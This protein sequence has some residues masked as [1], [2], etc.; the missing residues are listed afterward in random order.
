V[1]RRH[2]FPKRV[3]LAAFERAGG[4]CERCTA[5]L[6]PGKY[7]YDHR[8][9]LALGGESTLANCV[10]QCLACDGPKTYRQDIPAIAKSGRQRARHVGAKPRSSRP[11]PAGR[12][13]KWKRTLDGRTVLR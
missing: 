7:R 2:E 1:R 5:R 11:L 10:V 3:K 13:S 9:P 6:V 12:G 8:L 4:R